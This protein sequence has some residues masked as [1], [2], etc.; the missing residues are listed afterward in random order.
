MRCT[1]R[2]CLFSEVIHRGMH[3]YIIK[4]ILLLIVTAVCISFLVYAMMYFMPGSMTRIAPVNGSGDLLDRLFLRLDI[5]GGF[6]SGYLRYA[7]NLFFKLDMGRNAQSNRPVWDEIWIRMPQTMLLT[8]GS[9]FLTVIFGPILGI[10]AAINH[11]TWKDRV[12]M[13]CTIIGASLPTYVLGIIGTI[14]FAVKLGW[15]QVLGFQSLKQLIMPIIVLSVGGIAA[16]ARMMRSNMI[17]I[18]IKDYIVTARAKGVRANMVFFKHATKNAVPTVITV[19]A[20]QLVKLIGG[21]FVVELV[22]PMPGIGTYLINSISSRNTMAI[23]GSIITI[24]VIISA[25]YVISDIACAYVNPRIRERY[26]LKT[27]GHQA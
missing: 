25:I 13:F 27:A 20:G 3:R 5:R 12:I 11:D 16:T 6:F 22:F 10:F 4:R 19:L 21:S 8:G 1:I 26:S 7:F 24:G 14:I 18:L 2:S 15:V 9:I 23:C 17:E